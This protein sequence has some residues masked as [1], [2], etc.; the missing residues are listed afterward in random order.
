MPT[1]RLLWKKVYTAVATARWSVLLMVAAAH[2]LT[3]WMLLAAVAGVWGPRNT[4]FVSPRRPPASGHGQDW[5]GCRG[6]LLHVLA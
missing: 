2:F 5:C 6:A 3:S 1:M 4:N